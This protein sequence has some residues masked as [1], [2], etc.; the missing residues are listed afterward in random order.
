[1]LGVCFIQPFDTANKHRLT[2]QNKEGAAWS[3]Q[4]GTWLYL[5][6]ATCLVSTLPYWGGL[7]ENSTKSS[8]CSK[9]AG[10][11]ICR[12]SGPTQMACSG[13]GREEQTPLTFTTGLRII[14]I[15]THYLS[16]NSFKTFY[17]W[18]NLLHNFMDSEHYLFFCLYFNNL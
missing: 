4:G 3:A 17:C 5:A 10:Y 16:S 18:N 13:E 12:F 7:Q 15:K 9:M 1:M 14:W 6:L 8:S 2:G 11:M